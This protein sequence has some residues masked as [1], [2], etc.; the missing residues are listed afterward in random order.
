MEEKLNKEACLHVN[1]FY[2]V[3]SHVL[4]LLEFENVLLTVDDF[5]GK[6]LWDELG[7]IASPQ[8]PIL[9]DV[10]LRHLIQ[11]V[12]PLEDLRASHLYFSSG[13]GPSL[14]V[15]ILGSV[16]HFR[17]IGKADLSSLLNSHILTPI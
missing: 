13:S 6:T 4:S 10:F 3:R 8:P 7:N 15:D 16:F 17:Q 14:L 2:F 1:A 9:S 11:F 12:V 5:E